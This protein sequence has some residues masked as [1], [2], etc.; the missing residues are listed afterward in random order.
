MRGGGH[1]GEKILRFAF[2]S[3]GFGLRKRLTTALANDSRRLLWIHRDIRARAQ[4]NGMFALGINKQY[5]D[6]VVKGRRRFPFQTGR[7]PFQGMV[8]SRRVEFQCT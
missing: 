4:L 8:C 5:V 7:L 1:F 3:I 6:K 2:G